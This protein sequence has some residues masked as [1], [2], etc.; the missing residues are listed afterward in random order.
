MVLVRRD[1]QCDIKWEGQWYRH[2]RCPEHVLAGRG[3]SG[4]GLLASIRL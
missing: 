2:G 4:R 1:R 3:Q